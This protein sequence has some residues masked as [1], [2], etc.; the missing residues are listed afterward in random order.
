[1]SADPAVDIPIRLT[2]RQ[3][4]DVQSA[5]RQQYPAA[6][7]AHADLLLGTWAE[8]AEAANAR[9]ARI[10]RRQQSF[11]AVLGIGPVHKRRLALRIE[12]HKKNLAKA[13]SLL[14]DTVAFIKK[15]SGRTRWAEGAFQQAN[16]IVICLQAA[17]DAQQQAMAGPAPGKQGDSLKRVVQRCFSDELRLFFE[18]HGWLVGTRPKAAFFRVL[19]VAFGQH[20]FNRA[21]IKLHT[22]RLTVGR[23]EL[24]TRI[25]RGVVAPIPEPRSAARAG[26]L[27]PDLIAQ[28]PFLVGM[29]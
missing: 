2:K 22:Q 6:G 29:D 15:G 24:E 1:M 25:R 16:V 3:E 28:F 19:C 10:W 12:R 14:A 27:S 11:G 21:T 18:K 9:G 7:A 20:S 4:A 13:L 8:L 5:F 26:G 17:V 23:W